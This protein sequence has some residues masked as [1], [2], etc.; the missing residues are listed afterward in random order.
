MAYYFSFPTE[1]SSGALLALMKAYLMGC[2]IS[3]LK[4]E[5]LALKMV[6][7]LVLKMVALTPLQ[8]G[9]WL[10]RNLAYEKVMTTDIP[11]AP[12]SLSSVSLR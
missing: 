3:R 9:C 1:N 12:V 6:D 5:M 2:L 11:L 7:Y 10:S 4:A 8:M